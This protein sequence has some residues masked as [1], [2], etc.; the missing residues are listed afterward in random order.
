MSPEKS[1]LVHLR[2]MSARLSKIKRK[3][4]PRYCQDIFLRDQL[5][6]LADI[7][8][9]KRALKFQRPRTAH[10]ANQKIASL[11][12]SEPRSASR[13]QDDNDE[14][15]FALGHTYRGKAE[16]RFLVHPGEKIDAFSSVS[17]H[18][19]L[20][21]VKGCGVCRRPHMASKFHSKQGVDRAL[22]KL[23]TDG[24]YSLAEDVF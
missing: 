6:T 22:Q 15:N 16:R 8:E 4:D 2:Y 24:A 17:G 18:K 12:C 9:V 14:T 13:Y 23:R 20:P 11:R 3:L 1:Q 19:R 21:K 7:S 5:I 10:D